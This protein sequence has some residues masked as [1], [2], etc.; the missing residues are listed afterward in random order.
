ME[1]VNLK[2][3]NEIKNAQTTIKDLSL[4][5]EELQMKVVGLSNELQ[6]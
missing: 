5:K 1:V 4:A 3:V 2:Q 6:I